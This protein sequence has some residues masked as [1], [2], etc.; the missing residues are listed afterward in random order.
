MATKFLGVDPLDLEPSQ[1]L[2][3]GDNDAEVMYKIADN[4]VKVTF[5][6]SSKTEQNFGIKGLHRINTFQNV[7]LSLNNEQIKEMSWQ[8]EKKY[9]K[10]GYTHKGKVDLYENLHDL[11]GY[12]TCYPSDAEADLPSLTGESSAYNMIFAA[13]CALRHKIEENKERLNRLKENVSHT[14]SESKP[15][16]DSAPQNINYAPITIPSRRLR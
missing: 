10:E 8:V 1:I 6:Y 14:S 9:N 3:N 5:A 4:N 11:C 7:T 12:L 15:R 2:F 13:A 16:S